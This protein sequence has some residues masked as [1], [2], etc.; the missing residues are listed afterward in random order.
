MRVSWIT[1]TAHGLAFLAS[2]CAIAP[3]SAHAC[4]EAVTGHS[5]WIIDKPVTTFFFMPPILSEWITLLQDIQ[6]ELDHSEFYDHVSEYGVRRGSYGGLITV[7]SGPTGTLSDDTI[8]FVLLLALA[9]SNHTPGPG[10]NFVIILPKGSHAALDMD[11]GKLTGG[12]YHNWFNYTFSGV[13]IPVIYSVIEP[14]NVASM[15]YAISHELYEVFT[16]PI[17]VGNETQGN[18]YGFG[19]WAT[20]PVGTSAYI[21]TNQRE[22]A[23]MCMNAAPNPFLFRPT[24][25]SQQGNFLAQV[26]SEQSC[27]CH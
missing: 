21:R 18:F 11:Q 8:Q 10:E 12:G 7:P 25:T 14:D 4:P 22:I 15:V 27:A 13:Q 26:W 3:S 2:L 6:A 24:W 17:V 20:A 5:G 19:W 23:D 9:N 16:D 1:T